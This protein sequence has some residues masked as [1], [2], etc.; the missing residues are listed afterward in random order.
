MKSRLHPSTTYKLHG[1]DRDP[2]QAIL[3]NLQF[4][5]TVAVG[6]RPLIEKIALRVGRTA[7]TAEM[8]I[9]LKKYVE[10]LNNHL[11]RNPDWTMLT[12]Q[13]PR[14]QRWLLQ[15]QLESRLTILIDCFKNTVSTIQSTILFMIILMTIV[16]QQ[17]PLKITLEKLSQWMLTFSLEVKAQ[18]L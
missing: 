12:I 11:N 3:S 10:C 8:Q 9:I 13:F 14:Q 7:K 5:P 6:G 18:K 1:T 2:Q 15:Q 16:L 4:V 17:S